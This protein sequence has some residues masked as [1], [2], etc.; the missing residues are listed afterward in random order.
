[1]TAFPVQER[2]TLPIPIA[3]AVREIGGFPRYNFS[4]LLSLNRFPV[5]A[6][7]IMRNKKEATY[8]KIISFESAIGYIV[9]E[10]RVIV[11]KNYFEIIKSL[12]DIEFSRKV[13][14]CFYRVSIPIRTQAN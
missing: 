6:K 5:K 3:V 14:S 7:P 2:P 13:E 11:F 1:M 9:M 10:K 12:I 8:K 4:P